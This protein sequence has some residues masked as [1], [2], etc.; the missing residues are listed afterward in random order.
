[1]NTS[2]TGVLRAKPQWLFVNSDG[3]GTPT[4][5]DYNRY[6]TL[7]TNGTGDNQVDQMWRDRRTLSDATGTDLLDLAG[8]LTNVFGTTMQLAVVKLLYIANLGQDD[9]S[10][11]YTPV[12]GQDLLVGGAGNGGHAWASLFNGDQDAKARVRS[13][14]LLMAAAP[15]DGY[16]VSAGLRDVLE[17]AYDGSSSGDD[18]IY[19]IVIMGC[20]K[21]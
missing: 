12:D 5:D 18:I 21:T 20:T 9:G 2:L 13:G 6:R 7:L 19:D 14:G 15:M 1:M 10:G 3:I 8:G 16:P 11:G 4:D 17:V